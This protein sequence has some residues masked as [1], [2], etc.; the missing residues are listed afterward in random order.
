MQWPNPFTALKMVPFS[1]LESARQI[2]IQLST[3]CIYPCLGSTMPCC[4]QGAVC[5]P[6]AITAPDLDQ[7][8]GGHLNLALM[9]PFATS[10]QLDQ[11]PVGTCT[12]CHTMIQLPALLTAGVHL[13]EPYQL[14][15]LLG[16]QNTSARR[17]WLHRLFRTI[18]RGTCKR[19]ICM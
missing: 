18:L 11:A 17:S 16:P 6:D 19:R 9:H 1:L 2:A 12:Y 7:L 13:S 10:L 8:F 5:R 3:T 15:G 14:S 4:I